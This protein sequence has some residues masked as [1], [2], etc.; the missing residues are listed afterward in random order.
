MIEGARDRTDGPRV[1]PPEDEHSAGGDQLLAQ[2]IPLR[3]RENEPEETD[4]SPITPRGRAPAGVFDPP[5][6]PEPA[7]GYSVWEQPIEP[8]W[9]SRRPDL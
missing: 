8:G 7:E 3:R 9:I 1:R 5:E 6:D 4:L 2:I